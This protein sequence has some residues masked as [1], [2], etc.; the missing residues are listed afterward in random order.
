MGL[1]IDCA[2]CRGNQRRDA[3]ESL[4]ITT[5]NLEI[6]DTFWNLGRFLV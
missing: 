1:Y 5:V 3:R 4:E 2:L 6:L